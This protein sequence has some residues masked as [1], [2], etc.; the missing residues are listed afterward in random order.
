MYVYM[1]EPEA[2]PVYIRY[3]R[4]VRV[5]MGEGKNKKG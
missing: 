3:I 2:K 4:K 1:Q 5:Q